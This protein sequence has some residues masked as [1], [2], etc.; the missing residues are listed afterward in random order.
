M[1]V[2]ALFLD[3]MEDLRRRCD[4][5]ASEYD[6]VQVAGLLR[7]LTLDDHRPWERVNEKY[8]LVVRCTWSTMN[9][10]VEGAY[11]PRLWLDPALWEV[12]VATHYVD[13]PEGFAELVLKTRTES[14]RTFLR[15]KVVTESF[16]GHT[17]Q[18]PLTAT[19]EDLILHFSNREGGVH[20]DPTPA[21]HPLLERTLVSNDLA[22]RQTLL[23]TGRVIHRALEP[24]AVRVGLD[25]LDGHYGVSSH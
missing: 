8:R 19:V 9:A 1:R 5:R 14:M 13:V 11:L 12:F 25:L 24:L 3:T 6:M 16:V 2:Q 23:A 10:G 20:W 4:L 7:R 18:Q 17:Q 21:K 15:A 22:L